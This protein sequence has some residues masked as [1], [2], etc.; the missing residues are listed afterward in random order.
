MC[1]QALSRLGSWAQLAHLL[2]QLLSQAC[3]RCGT[4]PQ[5]FVGPFPRRVLTA[6]HLLQKKKRKL[7]EELEPA[8]AEPEAEPEA[9]GDAAAPSEAPAKKKK[10]K[11]KAAEAAAAAEVA[12]QAAA[13]A[14][15]E[16]TLGAPAADALEGEHRGSLA[17]AC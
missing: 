7:I 12:V 10:K 14:L 1:S 16:D 11:A 2:D 5:A 8:V 17:C 13:E 6:L 9:N 4:S 3:A 15:L